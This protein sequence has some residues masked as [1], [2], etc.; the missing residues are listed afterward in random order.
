MKIH[1]RKAKQH[2]MNLFALCN[3]NTKNNDGF[4]ML[5]CQS[6]KEFIVLPS[7]DRC[8]HC[9]KAL[10]ERRTKKGLPKINWELQK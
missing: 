10:N 6:P 4:V 2:P 7:K 3:Q 5:D 1:V 9:E 8:K